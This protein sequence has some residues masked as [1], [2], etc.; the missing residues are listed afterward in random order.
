M[1]EVEIGELREF[2]LKHLRK[3]RN[4]SERSI[5]YYNLVIR[6]MY[7]VIKNK[8]INKKQLAMYSKRRKNT[9]VL[10]KDELSAFFN[11]C[12]NHMYKIIFMMIYESA[13]SAKFIGFEYTYFT[14]YT[15]FY[16]D[17]KCN[18]V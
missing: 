18:K 6:F 8:I 16:I 11:A 5:N 14:T 1:E 17:I 9:G 10:T 13:L 15:T 12:E 7:E 3:E 4:L 2:L